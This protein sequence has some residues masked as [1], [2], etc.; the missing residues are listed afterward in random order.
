MLMPILRPAEFFLTRLTGPKETGQGLVEYALIIL[1]VVMGVIIILGLLG[2][3]VQAAYQFITESIP[4][5]E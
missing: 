2:S 1:M 4:V 5:G 3:E